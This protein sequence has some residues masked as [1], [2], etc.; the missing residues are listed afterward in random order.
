MTDN[1]AHQSRHL[2]NRGNLRDVI[3]LLC[4]GSAL[5]FRQENLAAMIAGG[6]VLAAGCAIHVLTKGVLI[7]NAVL[8]REGIYAIVRNPYYLGNYLIDSSFCLLSGNLYLL[9]AYPFLFFWAYGPTL[10]QEEAT[11]HS[12][13]GDAFVK[14]AAETPQIFPSASAVDKLRQLFAGF[15]RKR[16]T[17]NEYKR[18]IRFFSIGCFILVL[19][20]LSDESWRE[21]LLGARPH[22]YDGAVFTILFLALAFASILIPRRIAQAAHP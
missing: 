6:V 12:I 7:R 20:D 1:K 18:I 15:S 19:R 16:L 5:L 9:A 2:L 21:L 10:K 3:V 4:V 17:A 22:D 11:L 14:Y 8:C 13:H